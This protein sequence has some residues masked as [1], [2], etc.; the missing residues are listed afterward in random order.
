V[1][2]DHVQFEKRSFTSRNQIAANP[3]PLWLSVPVKTKGQ[4]QKATIDRLEIDNTIN[5]KSTH[6]KS[7]KQT[8]C[9]TPFFEHYEQAIESIY[10]NDWQTLNLLCQ[11]STQTFLEI[12]GIKTQ[13]VSSSN[14]RSRSTKSDLISDLCS[15]LGASTYIS[16][17]FGRDYLNQDTFKSAGIS[18]LFHDYQHP[19]YE[20]HQIRKNEDG[21]KTFV[22]YMSILD[23]LFNAGNDARAILSS[24]ESLSS[25]WCSETLSFS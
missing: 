20:Q 8:Y 19:I 14:L 22:P 16:G 18:I 11:A 12:L 25:E 9:K 3:A 23:L 13:I 17:P 7:I 10:Q 24:T 15:E 6:W 1:I 21:L 4:Y 5:W 2:L